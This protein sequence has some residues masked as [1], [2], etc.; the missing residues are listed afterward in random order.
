MFDD[1]DDDDGDVD[2]EKRHNHNNTLD[3]DDDEDRYDR[4]DDEV[5][6]GEGP[7]VIQFGLLSNARHSYFGRR[8]TFGRF[9]GRRLKQYYCR[10]ETVGAGSPN[11]Y[12]HS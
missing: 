9:G 11:E 6:D 4:G 5:V 7:P 10:A 3:D 12:H 1:D 2:D 8:E